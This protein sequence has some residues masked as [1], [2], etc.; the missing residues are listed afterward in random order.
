M[1]EKILQIAERIQGLRE[2][3]GISEQE[4]CDTLQLT[5]EAYAEYEAGRRDFSFS[6]LYEIARRLG[7]D[8]TE[9]I[10]GDMPRLSRFSL[11]RAGEGL[12]I[13]RRKGFAYQHMAYLFKNRNSEPFR[14]VARYDESLI[15]KP[16]ALSSHAGHEFDYILSGT[17]LV[18]IEDHQMELHP[19]DAIYYDAHN[20]HGMIAAGGEDCTFLAVISGGEQDK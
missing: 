5:P 15:G 18:Q 20:Q 2:L 17:L 3:L 13:E 10:T 4:M 16:I 9:L 8:I 19:G 12:P 7:V 6:L 1:N 11:I 14:V